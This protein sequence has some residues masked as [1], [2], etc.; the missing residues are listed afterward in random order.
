MNQLKLTLAAGSALLSLG[1]AGAA[2][3]DEPA[4]APPASAPAAA[5]PAASPAAYPSMGPTISANPNP[6]SFD[7]GPLGKVIVNGVVSGMFIGQSNPG[8]DPWDG[9]NNHTTE[10]DASNAMAVVQKDD[11][12]LQFAVQAGI[13]SF[14]TVGSSYI[15]ATDTPEATFGWAPV[16]YVKIAPNSMFNVQV[17]QLPTLIGAELPFTYQNAN[18]ERGLLWNTEPLISRGIQGNFT[19]GPWTVSVSWNDGFYSN[20]YTTISGLVTYTFKNTDAI[21]FSA[22]GNTSRNYNTCFFC[23]VPFATNLQLQQGQVYDLIATIN[24]GKVTV[25]PY[26]QYNNVPVVPGITPGGN[27]WGGAVIAKV[28][29]TDNFSLAGR[30]EYEGSNGPANLLY[31][32][33]SNAFSV[34]VTPTY[35]KGI[36]FARAELSYVSIG[37]GTTGLMLGVNGDKTNQFRGLIEAGFN[38]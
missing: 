38:F 37:S 19:D 28:G 3:A 35:T 6:A 26:I 20:E 31:G 15:R 17:G 21:T 10:F 33:G 5:A 14:P 29:I 27:I 11:G 9:T 23:N 30:L 8:I 34:T 13:Y 1:F 18:I 12:W 4:S 7:A 16:A 22:S 2:F 24:A 32:P 36:F 25:I